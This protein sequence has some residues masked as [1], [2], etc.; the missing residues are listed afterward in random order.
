MTQISGLGDADLVESE[1][2]KE[3]VLCTMTDIS[4]INKHLYLLIAFGI[5]L[6][7]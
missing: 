5:K 4:C 6:V 2:I 1:R 7:S 3:T